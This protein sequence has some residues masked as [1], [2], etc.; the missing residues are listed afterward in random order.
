M[1][2]TICLLIIIIFCVNCVVSVELYK[3]QK[4]AVLGFMVKHL[5]PLI[6]EHERVTHFTAE[7]IY[8]F[9]VFYWNLWYLVI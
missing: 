2:L 1:I 7:F 8:L 9:P 6:A 5:P 3:K 4:A